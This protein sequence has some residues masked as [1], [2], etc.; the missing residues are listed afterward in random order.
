MRASF[1]APAHAALLAI[2]LSA[3]AG[4]Q[5]YPVKPV[6]IVAPYPPG[7]GVDTS[8]RI[9]A[10]A[11]SEVTGQQF[12]VDNRPGAA[13]QIGTEIAARAVPDGYTLLLGNVGPNA[14]LPASRG[15][16]PY[17]AVAD[18]AP[19]SLVAVSEYAVTVHPSFPARGLGA[20][21]AVA[22]T[23]RDRITFGSTGI[24][25]GP[26]LAGELMNALA[27][28]RLYHVPY[29]GAAGVTTAL[30]SGEVAMSFSTLPSVMPFRANGKLRI[31]A[32]TGAKRSPFAPD[33]PAVAETVPGYEVTQWY[34]VLAP[35]RTDG[36]IVSALS[37]HI[38]KAL[39]RD[40]VRRSY[41]ASGAEAVGTA[42]AAFAQLISGEIA[43]YRKIFE[44]G[45]V[46]LD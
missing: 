4:A 46:K 29:K 8:A 43:K 36:I 31:L 21:I 35:A 33:I 2:L 44:S 37:A 6:R 42:P 3:S 13:G 17:D 1:S 9:I 25:S 14:I 45:A 39:A 32:V 11:L 20:L 15:N 41:A 30:L 18:F 26:H 16:L 7:G 28:I 19:V 38:A 24:A 23:R 22:R 5:T 12:I 27:K 10:Q 40:N 34:G